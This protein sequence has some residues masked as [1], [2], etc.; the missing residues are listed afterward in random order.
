MLLRCMELSAL[1]LGNALN[2]EE[3][4]FYLNYKVFIVLQHFSCVAGNVAVLED[5]EL[6]PTADNG[7]AD[8]VWGGLTVL[9]YTIYSDIYKSG[10][11]GKN[12]TMSVLL[13]NGHHCSLSIQSNIGSGE[14]NYTFPSQFL[15]NIYYLNFLMSFNCIGQ[16]EKVMLLPFFFSYSVGTWKQCILST[17]L[18]WEE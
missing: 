8:A 1:S 10:S 12:G 5:S 14:G 7:L 2:E 11:A 6:C 15:Y 17:G 9:F 13:R 4:L 16:F 18:Q 3:H